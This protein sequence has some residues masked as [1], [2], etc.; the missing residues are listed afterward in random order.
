MYS[1]TSETI[2]GVHLMEVFRFS[3]VIV[4]MYTVKKEKKIRGKAKGIYVSTSL[5]QKYSIHPIGKVKLLQ[6]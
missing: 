3:E 2:L 4:S 1:K 6:V 5:W